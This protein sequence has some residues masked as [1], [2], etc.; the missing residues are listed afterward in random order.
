MIVLGLLVLNYVLMAVLSPGREPSVTIPYSNTAANNGFIQQVEAGNVLKVNTQGDTVD[1]EFKKEVKY[2]D[3]KAEPAK[4]FETQLPSYVTFSSNNE[5]QMLLDASKVETSVTPINDGRGFFTSLL[6]GF[7]PVILLV[8]LFIWLCR[9]AA[10][11]QLGAIGSFGRSRARLDQQVDRV[12][13]RGVHARR[14]G[15]F[16]R[17]AVVDDARRKLAWRRGHERHRVIAERHQRAAAVGDQRRRFEAR[18]LQ[19][20]RNR[21]GPAVLEHERLERNARLAAHAAH[22][23][24]IH[25]RR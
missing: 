10:G 7:G 17:P 15:D 20:A 2:P 3:S 14:A 9:R 12:V 16:E 23:Q 24:H 4:N 25:E 21:N 6:L 18:D 13:A 5:L 11:D 22:G 1:G 8:F 19:L